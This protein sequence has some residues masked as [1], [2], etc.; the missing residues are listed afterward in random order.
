MNLS[1][2]PFKIVK[3]SSAVEKPFAVQPV[4]Y[5]NIAYGNTEIPKAKT[6]LFK[7]ATVWTNEKEGILEQTDVLIKNGKI[8]LNPYM[9]VAIRT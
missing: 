4:T 6:L 9:A 1:G 7:N 5:P 2:A 8:A 3:D